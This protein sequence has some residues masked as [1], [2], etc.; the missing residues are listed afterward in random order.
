MLRPTPG[1]LLIGIHRELRDL[2]LPEL[3]AGAVA[4]QMRAALHALECVA[5][6][7]DLQASYLTAD[8]D[9]LEKTMASLAEIGAQPGVRSEPSYSEFPG[10][11][12]PAL[13]GLLRRNLEL[14]TALDD[15][16]RGRHA[17]GD[18][19]D[20]AERIIVELH[21]RMIARAEVAAGV[22]HG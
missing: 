3:P 14:Q 5:R 15:L 20:E 11:A 12:D 10:T 19:D 6:T 7:W 22:D 21:Q 8:N 2:V 4:R 16:Q 9:D 1:E 13:L 17:R 18:R